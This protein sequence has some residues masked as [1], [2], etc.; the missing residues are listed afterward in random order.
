MIGRPRILHVHMVALAVQSG[1]TGAVTAEGCTCLTDRERSTS[2]R[3]ETAIA[4]CGN[5]E[6]WVNMSTKVMSWL[7][8]YHLLYFSDSEWIRISKIVGALDNLSTLNRAKCVAWEDTYAPMNLVTTIL[9]CFLSI[10]LAL[11]MSKSHKSYNLRSCCILC[12]CLRYMF[13]GS[14]AAWFSFIS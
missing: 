4:K 11:A 13:I 14:F 7:H 12:V 8:S 3:G 9:L 6:I 5:R 1:G 10:P 2:N